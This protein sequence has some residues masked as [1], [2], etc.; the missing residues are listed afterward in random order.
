MFC[1]VLA[2]RPLGSCKALFWNLLKPSEVL[3][4]RS[5][6]DS[7]SAYFAYRWRR[8]PAPR[9]LAFDRLTLQRLTTTTIVDYMFVLVLQKI[10]S[11]S[12]LLGQNILLLCHSLSEKG[13]RTTD[14]PFSSCCVRFL[15]LL[16]VFIQVANFMHM[17]R[18]FFSVFGEFQ[19]PPIG[20]NMNYSVLS[21]SQ[22]IR[23][24][25]NILKTIPRKTEKKMW[26]WSDK[27]GI[28]RLSVWVIIR[29]SL[30]VWL[31]VGIF[32]VWLLIILP[33]FKMCY[34]LF[35][36]LCVPPTTPSDWL[37][38]TSNNLLTNIITI[39]AN[40]LVTEVIKHKLFENSCD[41]WHH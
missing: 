37:N 30:S 7:G 35:S 32:F 40:K 1:I 2:N 13:L 4:L 23:L 26:T 12:E 33:Y 6:M 19:A 24:D 17:L 27:S 28:G 21:H 14:E 31:S 10:F 15:P 11:L 36:P 20:W 29:Y 8:R 22:W 25:V 39:S 41:L 34:F 18:R 3:P 9:P 16:S 38:I 5:R